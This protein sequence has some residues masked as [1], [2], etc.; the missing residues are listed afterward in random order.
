MY[1][2]VGCHPTRCSELECISSTS[3]DASNKLCHEASNKVNVCNET[4]NKE[5][6]DIEEYFEK[7]AKLVKENPKKIVAYGEIGL[8]ILKKIVVNIFGRL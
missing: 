5:F 2:T 1:L 4:P 7:V 3:V 6:N 8:G